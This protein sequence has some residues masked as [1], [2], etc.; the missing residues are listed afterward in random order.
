MMKKAYPI[1]LLLLLPMLLFCQNNNRLKISG[2]IIEKETQETIPYVNI[3]LA[4]NYQGTVSNELGAFEI[5]V[6]EFPVTLV[7]SHV[8]YQRQE[9]VINEATT[10]LEV[11]LAFAELKE[12]EIVAKRSSALY[13]IIDKALAQT[14]RQM[15]K[16]HFG[17][18]F[19]RQTSKND[20]TYVELYEI[21]Y[22]TKFNANGI[23]DWAIHQG[24]YALRETNDGRGVV[25]NKNFTLIDR[26]FPTIHP[27]VDLFF[28]PISPAVRNQFELSTEK[29]IQKEE[30]EI[31]VIAFS[32]IVDNVGRTPTMAGRVYIDL[33]S[34]DILKISGEFA[35]NDLKVISF[36]GKGTVDNYVLHYET[37]FQ[38][39]EAGDL[40]MEY[41]SAKQTLDVH[42]PDLPSKHVETQSLL[43]F[44]EY[45]SPEKKNKKLGGRLQ[46]RKSDK[47][48]IEGQEYDAD[49]WDDNPIVK[50]TPVEEKVIASF[51]EERQFG[52]IF[53]NN[54][55]QVALLPDI[56][57]DPFVQ[58]L[59]Q[60]LGQNYP[61]PEKVYLHLDKP[62]YARGENIWLKAYL[63]DGL[64]HR[65]LNESKALW[66][67]L[68]DPDSKIVARQ[69]L[70]IHAEGYAR[71]DI[72]IASHWLSGKYQIRAYTERMR[73]FDN[74]YFFTREIEVFNNKPR[75][76]VTSFEKDFDVQFFPE[77]GDLVAGLT[78]QVA[79]K[80][81]DQNGNGIEIEGHIV[82]A[83]GTVIRPLKTFHKGMNGFVLQPELGQQYYAEV[84]YK[85]QN[86][87]FELPPILEEGYVISVRNQADKNLRVRVL[88]T[89]GLEDSEVYLIGQIRGQVYYKSKG[90]LKNRLL[91]FEIPKNLFPSGILHLSLMN[92]E[93]QLF[94]E[95]L[96]FIDQEDELDISVDSHKKNYESRDEMVL[97]IEVKDVN[98]NPIKGHFSVA[99][100]D[101]NQIEL[102][103]YPID[104]RAYLLLSSDLKGK[105]EEVGQLFDRENP[106]SERMLD[107]VMMTN[108]WRR[109]SW[110]QVLATKNEG[111]RPEFQ[112]GFPICGQLKEADIKKYSAS[113]LALFVMGADGHA[114][115]STLVDAKGA[116]CFENVNFSD[117]SY[118]LVQALNQNG[119][120]VNLD[121][122]LNSVQAPKTEYFS[123]TQLVKSSKVTEYLNRNTERINEGSLLNTNYI[124]LDEVLVKGTRIEPD[125]STSI[126][127]TSSADVVLKMEEQ[128]PN[129]T[130]VL[131]VMNGKIPGLQ[132][133][134][135]VY[136]ARIRIT[137]GTNDPLVLFNGT[138]VNQY[139]WE[140]PPPSPPPQDNN[141]G[142]PNNDAPSTDQLTGSSS[143]DNQLYQFLRTLNPNEVDRIEVLKGAS[144]AIYGVRGANGVIAIYSK[145]TYTSPSPN[146]KTQLYP[147]FYTAREFYVPKYNDS[148]ARLDYQDRRATIY[149]NPWIKTDEQGKA[150]IRFYNTDI[151]RSFNVVMEGLATNGWM[152][153]QVFKIQ[154]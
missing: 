2:I 124:L 75:N 100:T 121:V 136:E 97:K 11:R 52:S 64:I 87:R 5:K 91:N 33:N 56:D 142:F 59:L 131:S 111:I 138:P 63:V 12:V 67:D 73:E 146:L 99:V 132:V 125:Q 95:R 126:H 110:Q 86:K 129:H 135:N 93:G 133:I 92:K 147:G 83:G 19:Y 106:K 145:T 79:F 74:N 115:Y 104:I 151:A 122:E 82:D 62:I 68:I 103:D 70:E 32:P 47:S 26:V 53:L 44:Y 9:L 139:N 66:V 144:A 3:M 45:Y 23:S 16:E 101:A 141:P 30:Q 154:P 42:Y 58:K 6:D 8:G 25:S 78:S 105:V 48:I 31:A 152:G 69:M 71:G 120:T 140:V 119:E 1:A 134:D 13:Q 130:N 41:I 40:L 127:G 84:K 17:R 65:P 34:Y 102:P 36:K 49:F 46:F 96:T 29:I 137:G 118:L 112:Q 10:N 116:F 117:T 98:G 21:F 60:Q 7:F 50:R 22:D 57:N 113:N 107:L 114:F 77:G 37:S 72:S 15:N 76:S 85:E 109:F 28:T 128:Y 14:L 90:T 88:S 150:E 20:S 27:E 35:S 38:Q 18:A 80:A 149:W 123:P 89:V 108:G 55:N 148:G 43:T 94:C 81:I 153:S 4:D 61:V 54:R 39:N 51:R 24:R 143:Y